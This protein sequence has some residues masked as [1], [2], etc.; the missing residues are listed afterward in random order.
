M[1]VSVITINY[2]N[3]EGLKRTIQSVISQVC[4]DFEYIVI[5]GGS[6]DGSFEYIKGFSHKIDYW[7]SEKDKGIYHAMNKGVA[8][9][10]GDYCIFINSG[11]SFYNDDV[12]KSFSGLQS[13]DDIIV[14]RVAIDKENGVSE[15][16]HAPVSGKLTLYHLYSGAIPHQGT[17]I[18]TDLLRKYPYDENLR[19]S[20][21]WKFFVQTLILDNCSI[22]YVNFFVS[23]YDL[24]GISSNNPDLMR[25]EKEDVLSSL[26]PSRILDDYR[27]MKSSECLTQTLTST[28]RTHYR[29][30]KILYRIG[31]ILIRCA[32]I[33][34]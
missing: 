5:D 7:I 1:K 25:H 22:N 32:V 28:L 26:F 27:Y 11:D 18:R 12:L 21:D 29:I 9:A 19:I 14:G 17:F 34:K 23:L 10:H 6:T 4:Q 13:Y 30:D 20:S 16:F 2:N 3:I 8:Q 15:I 24:H 31:K 33:L